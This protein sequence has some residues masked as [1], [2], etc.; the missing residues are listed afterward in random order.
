[1]EIME[2]NGAVFDK[3]SPDGFTSFEITNEDGTK[4]LITSKEQLVNR[5]FVNYLYEEDL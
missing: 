5:M 3:S 1:M 2:S 4:D